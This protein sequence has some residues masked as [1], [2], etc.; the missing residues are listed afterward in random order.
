M[1]ADLLSASYEADLEEFWESE[2]TATPVKTFAV[3]LHETGRSL[4]EKQ[5]S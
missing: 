5:Q 4:R 3:H 1:L 2:R